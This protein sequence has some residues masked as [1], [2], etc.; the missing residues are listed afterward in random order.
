MVHKT[1]SP[2]DDGGSPPSSLD[3]PVNEPQN[4]SGFMSTFSRLGDLPEW[5]IR[6]KH[7]Q[8]VALNW[9]IGFIASCGF[10][11]FGYDQGVLSALL[12]LPDYQK[13]LVLMTPRDGNNPLCWLDYPTNE[14]P[15]PSQRTGDHNTQAAGVAVYQIGSFNVLGS[16]IMIIGTVMQ[17]AAHEYGF[18]ATGRIVGGVG[19]SM[20]TSTNPTWQS[21]C[22]RAHQ[23]GFLIML[24]GALISGGIMIAYWVDYGFYF[25]A[26]SIRWRFPVAF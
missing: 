7:L 21:E 16:P 12:T 15:D 2:H 25:L 8:G 1:E 14:Q 24:S 23:R 3:G 11:M 9:S 19:N 18:F 20:V 26:G 17:A 5:K 6:G 13:N 4:Q 22:A 10:L